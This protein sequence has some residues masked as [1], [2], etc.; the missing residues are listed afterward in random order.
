MCAV[1]LVAEDNPDVQSLVRHTLE[2]DGHVVH[3]AMDGQEALELYRTVSPELVVLDLMMPRLSGFDLLRELDRTGERRA[4]IPILVLSSR[5]DQA[6]IRVG[7]TLGV[8]DY[9]TKPF[10]IRELRQ[11]VGALLAQ[12]DQPK[13]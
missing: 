10:M 2:A 12:R 9:I 7:E 13:D 3:S 4:D 6:D 8:A 1:I 5:S 11:R